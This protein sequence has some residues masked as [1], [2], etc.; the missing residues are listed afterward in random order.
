METQATVR[1]TRNDKHSAKHNLEHQEARSVLFRSCVCFLRCDSF[2]FTGESRENRI[3]C[4]ASTGAR[5]VV[6]FKKMAASA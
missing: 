2:I 4:A 1:R 6:V 3:D 5:Q